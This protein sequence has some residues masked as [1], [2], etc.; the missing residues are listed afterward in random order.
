MSCDIARRLL[1]EFLDDFHVKV[2]M[3]PEV[4][5]PVALEKLEVFLR[6]PCILPQMRQKRGFRRISSV[7]SATV[8]A[9]PEVDSLMDF[10]ESVWVRYGGRGRRVFSR[11]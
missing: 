5:S 2:D 3:G 6:A 7:F 4:N 8:N 10:P 1:E 9:D 11:R